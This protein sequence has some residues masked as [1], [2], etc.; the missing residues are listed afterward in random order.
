[1]AMKYSK[2]A[3]CFWASFMTTLC[4]ILLGC[5]LITADYNTRWVGF[6][7]AA[8]VAGVISEESGQI[9][10]E[11]DTMGIEQRLDI[12]QLWNAGQAAI[13][14]AEKAMDKMERIIKIILE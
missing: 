6:G 14:S 12:T 5:G 7:K 13:Q 3:R 9:K 8:P 10:L 4:L 1:M 2:K 11:I